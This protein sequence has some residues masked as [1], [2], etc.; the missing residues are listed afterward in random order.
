MKSSLVFAGA[1]LMA[2]PALAAHWNVDY[3]RSKLG[4][5][6]QWSNEAFTA[7][8]KS[9]KADIEFDPADL[10]H[11][12]ADVTINLSSEASGESEFDDGLKGAMGF[13][14]SQFPAA[15]FVAGAFT[16]QSGDRYVA[17]GKLSLRG[18]TKEVTRLHGE[19]FLAKWFCW[20][21]FSRS[22]TT[23]HANVNWPAK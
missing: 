17:T 16:H 6:T 5:S 2:T 23:W 22:L 21:G 11:A 19:D 3:T 1:L 10:A 7:V 18:I 12:H 14:V 8:F 20:S 13:Q 4:F 15:H 9:W